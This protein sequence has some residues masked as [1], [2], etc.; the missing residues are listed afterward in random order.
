MLLPG[1]RTVATTKSPGLISVTFSP[2]ASTRPKPSCPVTRN[3][4][5]GGA[6]PYSAALISLSVPST[7]TRR[8]RT[9]T[10]RPFGTEL[11][12][13]PSRLA[14]CALFAFRGNTATAFTLLSLAGFGSCCCDSR[15]TLLFH[16]KFI[17][18]FGDQPCPTGLVVGA[19]AGAGIAMEVPVERNIAVP[20]RIGLEHCLISKYRATAA[21]IALESRE[22]ASADF[23]CHLVKV[24][25]SP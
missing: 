15:N 23:I 16:E 18:H 8:T 7:P 4:Y 17:N 6:A 1:R 9:S 10:P 12:S 14:K 3:S 19:Y 11:I 5:P 25:Q 24:H 13:G 2:T 20:V 22:K 21:F